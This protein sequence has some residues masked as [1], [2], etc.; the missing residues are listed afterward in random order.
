MDAPDSSLHT[1]ISSR[2]DQNSNTCDMSAFATSWDAN[3]TTHLLP[4]NLPL[5]KVQRAYDRRPQSP[6]S[7]K[8]VRFGKVWK[9]NGDATTT[10]SANS[11]FGAS[12]NFTAI[13]TDSPVKAVKK[14]R[15][16]NGELVSTWE[17]RG[18]PANRRIVTRGNREAEELL[19]LEEHEQEAQPQEEEVV[20]VEI[21]NEDGS[22]EEISIEEELAQEEWED[23]SIT[24][25]AV[26]DATLMHLGEIG[27]GEEF[28]LGQE[29]LD[30]A[31]VLDGFQA[32]GDVAGIAQEE[33]PVK[34]TNDLSAF[35]AEQNVQEELSEDASNDVE[36]EGAKLPEPAPKGHAAVKVETL[37]TESASIPDGFVSPVKERRRRPISEV[38]K[39][40][41]ANRRRTLPVNFAAQA[42]AAEPP[43]RAPQEAEQSSPEEP[44]SSNEAA[45][46][47]YSGDDNDRTTAVA[48]AMQLGEDHVQPGEHATVDEDT[49]EDV[50]Q[51][52]PS[53]LSFGPRAVTPEP[54]QE[55]DWVATV[56]NT[57]ETPPQ[58]LANSAL[59]PVAELISPS[60]MPSSPVPSILGQHPRLPLRRSPR[61]QTT[62]PLKRDA[63]TKTAD[64]SHLIAFT[65][66]K[67]AADME[68]A[69]QR[70]NAPSSPLLGASIPCGQEDVVETSMPALIRSSSAPPEEPQ[71]SPRK[72][73]QARISDDTALLQAFISRAAESKGGRRVSII[74]TRESL[75]NRRNSDTVRQALASPA[76]RTAPVDVLADL[77][78][79]SPSPRKQV[80][81]AELP[82]FD[83]KQRSFSGEDDLAPPT[84]PTKKSSRRSGRSKKKP[85][86]L[87]S[88]VLSGPTKISV[89]G[90][91][92]SVV[93]KK[94][95]AQ[96]L[97]QQ[98]RANTRK[99][100]G[101]SVMPP[102]RL[103]KMAKEGNEDIEGPDDTS[104]SGEKSGKRCITWAETLVSYYQAEC[105]PEV[106]MMIDELAEASPDASG[107]DELD[108]EKASAATPI[109]ASETPSKPKLRRLK[110]PRTASTPA[111]TAPSA[112]V[113]PAPEAGIV[114]DA[115]PKA[116]KTSRIATPA[117]PKGAGAANLLPD[118]VS[119]QTDTMKKAVTTRKATSRLPAPTA[120]AAMQN[121]ENSLIASPPKKRAKVPAMPAAPSTKALAPKLDLSKSL[122]APQKRHTEGVE[123]P[124]IASPAKKGVRT[125]V[126]FG[127]ENAGSGKEDLPPSLGSPAKKR[128]RRAVQF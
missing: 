73:R 98:T 100:K 94:S 63:T 87:S 128:T 101:G 50:E 67:T 5:S 104:S 93:L 60:K 1:S 70:T 61:R 2:S 16:G 113:A 127:Q 65:P 44:E 41:V 80:M 38:R 116:K 82:E 19:E 39:Q 15:T 26:W 10:A 106:S 79:N 77:D 4:G 32:G 11:I 36:H 69:E 18:S 51:E 34:D 76:E 86:M 78:P 81:S 9:R 96:E 85:E 27:Q 48:P 35:E 83:A 95:E 115:R 119:N 43:S 74:A 53:L 71:M 29:T 21:H 124:G 125:G 109:P 66:L 54:I 17:G 62:S 75:Q 91:A 68:V 49:W 103:T 97:A 33:G 23:E 111:K 24:E 126:F 99:N 6:F 118:E 57:P 112:P 25:E 56:E 72:P 58:T 40:S 12:S 107:P 55:M 88:S 37:R 22:I 84:S 7:R 42:P 14:M 59:E 110:P 120:A 31:R 122:A 123:V 13:G 121:K 45:E 102:L 30:L 117:K 20:K 89:K 108:Q 64:R 52:E 92:D 105:E 3:D 28:P 90:S 8:K 47:Y 46:Q 114:S